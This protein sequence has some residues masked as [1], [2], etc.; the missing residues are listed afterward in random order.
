[1]ANKGALYRKILAEY[2][3]LQAQ[4]KREQQ[5]RREEIYARIPRIAE[6]DK[7]IGDSGL[8]AVRLVLQE[9]SKAVERTAA[10]AAQSKA[11]R[12]EKAALLTEAG[13]PADYLEQVYHCTLCKDTGYV[14]QKPCACFKQRLL[15][16]AYDQANL[17]Q[18]LQTENF[19]YF[20]FRLY[21]A[22]PDP[23]TGISPRENMQQI[24]DQCIDFV[25]SFPAVFSNLLLYGGTGLGKTFLCNCIAKEIL[26]KGYT[27]LYVTAGQLCKMAEAAQFR[28]RDEEEEAP[29]GFL[30]DVMDTDL[31]IIDDLGTEFAT[32]LSTAALFQVINT[33]LLKRRHTLI[34]TNLSLRDL[35]E[36][37]SDRILSRLTGTYQFLK[38]FGQDIRFRKQI[39]KDLK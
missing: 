23:E 5:K 28:R 14:D 34:S 3:E 16:L 25:E 30:E 33:R 12:A 29:E 15:E 26:D 7:A 4:A 38:F 8:A 24:F 18:I 19:D 35:R 2:D 17:S 9:P 31:L 39:K 37:Y 6:L 32:I 1:M 13:Y 22:E 21:D 11:N 36:Q 10:L 27:V 20:D